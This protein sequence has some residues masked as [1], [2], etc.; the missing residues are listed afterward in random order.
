MTL[1]P[2]AA[3]LKAKLATMPCAVASTAM[4]R[5]RAPRPISIGYSLLG[6]TLAIIWL[7]E[8]D[9]QV[10]LKCD[11]HLIEVLKETYAGIGHRTHLDRRHWIAIKLDSDVP[12]AEVERLVEQSYALVRASLTRKQ[13]AELGAAG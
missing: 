4:T 9:P 10:V 6:K 1:H 13:Q 11:P 2:R 12:E 3:A 8:N 7:G 5:G